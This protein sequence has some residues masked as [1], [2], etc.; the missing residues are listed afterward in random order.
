M[1]RG[2]FSIR[3]GDRFAHQTKVQLEGCACASRAGA[4]VVPVWNKS[5]REHNLIGSEP[6]STRAVADAAVKA[7]GWTKPYHFDAVAAKMGR[8]YL[9]LLVANED[10]DRK[11]VTYNIYARHIQPVFMGRPDHKPL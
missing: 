8:R 6:S 11:N 3:V 9:D 4:D 2:K 1:R 5:N 10:V 7:L